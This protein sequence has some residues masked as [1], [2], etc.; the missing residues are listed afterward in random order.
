[1]APE[2]PAGIQHTLKQA[3]DL[4]SRVRDSLRLN[5]PE[6]V[7]ESVV[8]MIN[9]LKERQVPQV[10]VVDIPEGIYFLVAAKDWPGLSDA[11]LAV[12]HDKGYNLSMVFG[13]QVVGTPYSVVLM[14][15]AEVEGKSREEIE[16]DR[17]E[18]VSLLRTVAKGGLDI[19]TL[20]GAEGRKLRVYD[21]VLK[22]IDRMVEEG[23]LQREIRDRIV[24]EDG[25]LIKFIRSRTIA[26]LEER[27]PRTLAEIVRM[28]VELA[29]KARKNPDNVYVD[30]HIFKVGPEGKREH[31]MVGFT[32]AG[33]SGL[34]KLSDVLHIFRGQGIVESYRKEFILPDGIAIVRVEMDGNYQRMLM[35]LREELLSLRNPRGE[36]EVAPGEEI[37]GRM[38]SDR[39]VREYESTG[40]PQLLTMRISKDIYRTSAVGPVLW[41]SEEEAEDA[42]EEALRKRRITVQDMVVRTFT[43]GDKKVGIYIFKVQPN[44]PMRHVHEEVKKAL[45]EVFG[46]VRDFDESL[47]RIN[48]QKLTTLYEILAENVPRK[49]IGS[50][51]YSLK[52]DLRIMESVDVLAA[53]ISHI[54]SSVEAFLEERRK[55]GRKKQERDTGIYSTSVSRYEITTVVSL[56]PITKERKEELQKRY[57]KRISRLNIY[58]NEVNTFIRRKREEK[59]NGEKKA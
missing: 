24:G 46:T 20:L 57:G 32:V 9:A 10:K 27:S 30:F 45:I 39:L 36:D 22:E 26:Y 6:V 23:K 25:E 44:V 58:G 51:F 52:D 33:R 19:R 1:M 53:I 49:F 48:Y 42:I 21:R 28:Q 43:R 35:S 4:E 16:R 38:V 18:M 13:T 8:D 55:G 50:I 34:V 2:G 11:S 37:F 59:E 5:V 15:V 29:E 14:R 40:I 3:E 31:T 7:E 47:R 12:V 54:F 56:K 17:E 41:E